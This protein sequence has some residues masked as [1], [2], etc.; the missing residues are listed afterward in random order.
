MRPC[1]NCERDH[2]LFATQADAAAPKHTNAVR[3]LNAN[4]AEWAAQE[5]YFAQLHSDHP[6][7]VGYH[8]CWAAARARAAAYRE[9]LALIEGN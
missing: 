6:D 3:V 9:A 1:Q 5:T 2:V 8:V 4:V 7:R